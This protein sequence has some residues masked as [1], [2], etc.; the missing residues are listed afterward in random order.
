MTE[1][2]TLELEQE[3]AAA[4]RDTYT[5]VYPTQMSQDN[6]VNLWLALH[7]TRNS[8]AVMPEKALSPDEESLYLCLTKRI[9]HLAARM[10]NEKS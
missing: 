8:Y 7:K 1:K 2:T 5:K 6:A 9:N 3:L 4:I 10:P